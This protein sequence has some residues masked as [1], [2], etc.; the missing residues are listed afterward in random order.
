MSTPYHIKNTYA[1]NKVAGDILHSAVVVKCQATL[2]KMDNRLL[3]VYADEINAGHISGLLKQV[4]LQSWSCGSLGLHISKDDYLIDDA[5][6]SQKAEEQFNIATHLQI[7]KQQVKVLEVQLHHIKN[8]K[9]I[10]AVF[11]KGLRISGRHESKQIPVEYL[12]PHTR[13][14]QPNDLFACTAYFS[15]QK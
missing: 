15:K 13:R 12:N 8:S 6:L 11:E 5:I 10:M 2:D 3:L 4:G 1:F 14:H 7:T 9:E